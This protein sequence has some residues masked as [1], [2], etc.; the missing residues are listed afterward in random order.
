MK[1]CTVCQRCY[2]DA[3]LSCEENHG[4]LDFARAGS[5][6]MIADYRL[7]FL[8]ERSAAVEVYRATHIALD[9]P[10][11][12]KIITPDSAANAE[13]TRL[14]LRSET[15]AAAHIVHPN[16]LR[17]YEAGSLADGDFYTVTESVSGETLRE[18]LRN[19]GSLS[20]L[21]AVTIAGQTAKALEAAHSGGLVH[22]A[23]SPANIILLED[24][25]NQILV[26]LQNF[27]FG[28]LEQQTAV[29]SISTAH[30]SIDALRYLSPEQCSGQTIDARTDI[31]SLGVVLYE[32]LCGRL[33]FNAPTAAAII[34]KQINEQ[35]LQQLRYDVR[36]LLTYV[37]KQSLQKGLEARLPTASNF[38]RQ[39]RQVEQL[40]A[41][42]AGVSRT[43]LKTS[44]TI[45]SAS[46]T[47]DTFEIKNTE[48]PIE[49]FQ[50]REII[51]PVINVGSTPQFSASPIIAES[52]VEQIEEIAVNENANFDEPEPILVEQKNTDGDFFAAEP[53]LLKRKE[54][55][56][57][58]F[59]SLPILVRK[60]QSAAALCESEPIRVKRKAIAVAAVDSGTAF[61]PI[62]NSENVQKT[63]SSAPPIFEHL[64][65]ENRPSRQFIPNGRPLLVGAGLLA[66]LASIGL[67]MFLY[68]QRQQTS[69]PTIAD[70]APIS[71]ASQVPTPTS[72]VIVET[73][74]VEP[75]DESEIE[76]DA[77]IIAANQPANVAKRENQ[78]QPREENPAENTAP[79]LTES[80]KNQTVREQSAENTRAENTQPRNVKADGNDQTALNASLNEWVTATNDRD[81]ER[82]MNYYAP[83]VNAY[84]RTRNA[85][86][87]AVRTEKKRIFERARVVDIQAG[88]PEIVVSP[89]GQTATMRFRKKYAIKEGQR[90]RS[91]EVIQELRWIKSNNGWKI[92]SER[93]V[94]V[95]NR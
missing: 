71:T 46:N 58:T 18:R 45:N 95:I 20:E 93:D 22:R 47:G 9:Q 16:I 33:P 65:N 85:S 82:Q 55:F 78:I 88:E 29:K 75:A 11:N 40:V 73:T 32:M 35:P 92:V 67:G 59:E 15:Q 70:A 37:L 64:T 1:V 89:D 51:T 57:P 23:V 19:V 49:N 86:P 38:V 5:R 21:E 79:Q 41:P 80:I 56:E 17:V 36:A 83:K 52:P 60:K 39:L 3:A 42:P 81:I 25:D 68:N 4:S 53:I 27:D 31:Y 90:N 48:L 34:F 87:D 77:P 26:K 28:G 62:V 8:L 94:K 74:A 76:T 84:Y 54:V 7:D 14:K 61:P 24:E 13:Q 69:E 10:F 43:I 6:E 72:S 63:P 66:L 44:S 91:G 50:P 12:I 30:S 2:E